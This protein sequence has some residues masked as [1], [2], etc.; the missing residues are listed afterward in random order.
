[1]S[2]LGKGATGRALRKSTFDALKRLFEEEIK[3]DVT[4]TFTASRL[5]RYLPGSD[6]RNLGS[7]LS[8]MSPGIVEVT[9]SSDGNAKV[10]KMSHRAARY[11][12][13]NPG[14]SYTQAMMKLNFKK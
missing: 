10:Y 12:A 4:Q 6:A 7:V 8:Y 1:M 14:A 2:L 9:G 13:E 5:I 3:G 11:L